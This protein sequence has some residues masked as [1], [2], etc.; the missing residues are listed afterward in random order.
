MTAER[1]LQAVPL[2][3]RNDGL[4]RIKV[5][6]EMYDGGHGWFIAQIKQSCMCG[7]WGM[8]LSLA[9]WSNLGS[10]TESALVHLGSTCPGVP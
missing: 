7:T 9:D 1:P 5:T 10:I 3:T 4:E 6:I 8:T 2:L